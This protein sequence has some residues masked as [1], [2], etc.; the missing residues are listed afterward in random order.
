MVWG[1]KYEG[2]QEL[3]ILLADAEVEGMKSKSARTKRLW[4]TSGM[5][6][7]ELI[8][9]EQPAFPDGLLEVAPAGVNSELELWQDEVREVIQEQL[10]DELARVG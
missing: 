5:L 3:S 2:V 7:H 6:R 4:V 10:W 9:M 8:K 1:R